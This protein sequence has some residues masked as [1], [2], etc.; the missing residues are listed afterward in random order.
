MWLEGAVQDG[1]SVAQMLRNRNET[2]GELSGAEP[3]DAS[4]DALDDDAVMDQTQPPEMISSSLGEVYDVGE[5]EQEDAVA[6]ESIGDAADSSAESV[7]PFASLPSLPADVQ[8]AFES[9]KLAIVRH[10]A[11]AW[12]EISRE[13]MLAVLGLPAG[14][15]PVAGRAIIPI[16][17]LACQRH[18]GL[19]AT[20]RLRK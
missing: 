16:G 3:L 7:R 9:F 15:C 12:D 8:E 11:A 4:A 17:T 1:W 18:V 5:V 13:D 6:D 10:R 14:I 19:S 20:L 2:L